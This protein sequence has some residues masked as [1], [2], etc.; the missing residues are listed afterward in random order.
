MPTEFQCTRCNKVFRY[1][2]PYAKH[3]RKW[4]CRP[5]PGTLSFKKMIRSAQPSSNPGTEPSAQLGDLIQK[6]EQL[7]LKQSLDS[8]QILA[9][10]EQI[11][12]LTRDLGNVKRSLFYVKENQKK[13]NAALLAKDTELRAQKRQLDKDRFL[14]KLRE[15]RLAEQQNSTKTV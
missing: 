7:V 11:R 3:L 4:T 14:C 10:A 5:A 13:A 9:Q 12:T 1:M 6:V 15:M 8:R 2:K